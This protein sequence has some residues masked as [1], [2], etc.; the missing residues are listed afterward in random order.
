MILGVGGVL[1]DKR[2]SGV[3][4][5]ILSLIGLGVAFYQMVIQTF[6]VES[7]FCSVDAT[8]ADCS[9]VLFVV[10]GYITIPVMSATLFAGIALLMLIHLSQE[11]VNW[12]DKLK[13]TIGLH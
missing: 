5:F 3:Y 8:G 1:A 2:T 10:A 13:S 6:P 11:K 7:A 9:E 4:A 12:Y